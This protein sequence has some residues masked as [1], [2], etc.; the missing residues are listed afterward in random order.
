M[1]KLTLLLCL[2]LVSALSLLMGVGCDN[3]TTET[4][5]NTY[6]DSTLGQDCLRCHSDSDNKIAQPKGQW[7]NSAHA[8]PDLIEAHVTLNGDKFVSNE[9][10]AKCHTSE[11]FIHF[12]TN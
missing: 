11:G 8:S 6:Y 4:N 9:C 2:L 12:T 3:L 5:N 10:G 1:R 7:A